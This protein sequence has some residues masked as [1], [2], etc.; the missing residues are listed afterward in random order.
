[1]Y[2]Q[3]YIKSRK[4]N[5]CKQV[6]CERYENYINWKCGRPSNSFCMECK[7]AHVTQYKAKAK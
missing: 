6:N 1:M 7:H 4:G 5:E 3:E 2:K